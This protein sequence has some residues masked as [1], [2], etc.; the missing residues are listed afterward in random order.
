MGLAGHHHSLLH[1][2]HIGLVIDGSMGVKH[3]CHIWHCAVVVAA[4]PA[5]VLTELF[6]LPGVCDGGAGE[7]V[8][9]VGAGLGGNAGASDVADGGE[10]IGV[11]PPVL[12]VEFVPGLLNF[13]V[14]SACQFFSYKWH[15]LA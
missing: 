8:G 13:D 1:I 6:A 3:P 11:E 10:N 5:V 14:N 2:A 4:R 15:F 7:E 12:Q 9:V